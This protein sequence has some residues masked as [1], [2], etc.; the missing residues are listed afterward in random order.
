M[1]LEDLFCVGIIR[2]NDERYRLELGTLFDLLADE[3]AIHGWKFDRQQDQRGWLGR[4]RLK[5][6]VTIGHN[7]HGDPVRTKT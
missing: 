4:R 2:Q 3:E 5:P 7:V 6:F 1:L